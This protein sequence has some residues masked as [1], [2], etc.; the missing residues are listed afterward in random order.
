M[1][2]NRTTKIIVSAELQ[3]KK[4]EQDLLKLQSKLASMQTK[5]AKSTGSPVELINKALKDNDSKMLGYI[6]NQQ[7]RVS[8][9]RT[10]IESGAAKR[11]SEINR[12]YDEAGQAR[13]QTYRSKY[14]I[15]NASLAQKKAESK[16]ELD[17]LL[18]ARNAR[19]DMVRSSQLDYAQKNKYLERINK[20]YDAQKAKSVEAFNNFKSLNIDAPSVQKS[21]RSGNS[22][23]AVAR[24]AELGRLA[25]IESRA[26]SGVQR[27]STE[28]QKQFRQDFKQGSAARAGIDLANQDMLARER[29][30]TDTA[31]QA[32][33]AENMRKRTQSNRLNATRESARVQSV[34]NMSSL[35]SGLAGPVAAFASGSLIQKTGELQ[36]LRARVIQVS[37]SLREADQSMSSLRK[38]AEYTGQTMSGTVAMFAR[39]APAM[40]ANNLST[41]DTLN[42]VSAFQSSLRAS[43]TTMDQAAAAAYQLSQSLSSGVL[44]GDE[45]NSVIEG[46]PAFAKA[47]ADSLG[48]T[49]G[50][51]KRLGEQGQLTTGI[52]AAAAAEART[53]LDM[54]AKSVPITPMQQFSITVDRLVEAFDK[55]DNEY[56]ILDSIGKM[57]RLVA[58]N[59]TTAVSAIVGVTAAMASFK[60]IA[61][62]T[63]LTKGIGGLLGPM[64]KSSPV[65][66]AA[67]RSKQAIA[68]K[69]FVGPM[70]LITQASS[71]A[72]KQGKTMQRLNSGMDILNIG[73]FITV[74]AQT[75]KGAGATLIRVFAGLALAAGP[76]V[77]A[78]AGIGAISYASYKAFNRKSN[79]IEKSLKSSDA[80]LGK[81]S[82]ELIDSEN[83]GDI[84]RI[85]KARETAKNARNNKMAMLSM[86]SKYLS[87]SDERFIPNITEKLDLSEQQRLED[88][89][90]KQATQKGLRSG[91][92]LAMRGALKLDEVQGYG[93]MQVDTKV[94]AQVKQLGNLFSIFNKSAL[95]ASGVKAEATISDIAKAI[96]TLGETSKTSADITA[97]IVA[98]NRGLETLSGDSFQMVNTAILN[99]TD[100]LIE[101]MNAEIENKI[102]SSTSRIDSFEKAGIAVLSSNTRSSLFQANTKSSFA[103]ND[104]YTAGTDST[105]RLS[106]E[107]LDR[108]AIEKKEASA[109]LALKMSGL[110]KD[111]Q[112]KLQ[113][114]ALNTSIQ[115]EETDRSEQKT[116]D[117]VGKY[118][119]KNVKM[120]DASEKKKAELIAKRSKATTAVQR[121]QLD[122]QIRDIVSLSDDAAQAI[123]ETKSSV[124]D[125]KKLNVTA[126]IGNDPRANLAD[127]NE[128][129]AA[130]E[131]IAFAAVQMQENIERE[132]NVER[133]GI[134]LEYQNGLESSISEMLKLQEEYTRKVVDLDREAADKKLANARMVKDQQTSIAND[135]AKMKFLDR[136]ARGQSV[137]VFDDSYVPVKAAK[138]NLSDA[139]TR[140]Q[141]SSG[142]FDTRK[143]IADVQ[144]MAKDL[145]NVK[146][147]GIKEASNGNPEFEVLA[148]QVKARKEYLEVVQQA[149]QAEANLDAT[150]RSNALVA[151]GMNSVALNSALDEQ[152]SVSGMTKGMSLSEMKSAKAGMDKLQLT[153]SE[154]SLASL[155]TSIENALSKPFDIKINPNTGSQSTA[156]AGQTMQTVNVSFEGRNANIRVEPMD[157]NLLAQIAGGRK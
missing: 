108:M 97:S 141:G 78:M 94:A 96:E 120:V 122:S 106:S 138:E 86:E 103:N 142:E 93:G 32:I 80:N 64:A 38:T 61:I 55:L 101:T 17:G 35:G 53:V 128:I 117:T 83:S 19:R 130:R 74:I 123:Q 68:P 10:K 134:L 63:T 82:K 23:D 20:N 27:R 41:Q 131:S 46:A 70:P 72:G 50:G 92:V 58:D 26:L 5:L 98:L 33:I 150:Q 57:F 149:I 153:A 54:M 139:Q 1:A 129:T 13:L 44:R 62:A 39:I 137:G 113:A 40:Q 111:R 140:L 45:L 104:D 18:A 59:A 100:R 69:G 7:K 81:A 77:A 118:L 11:R 119:E 157:V 152:A 30:K 105:K 151:Q 29:I 126:L 60:A 22:I 91:D 147:S 2:N 73:T 107:T 49:V 155:R 87:A 48:V 66:I 34:A 24:K 8:D 121:N 12:R 79:F 42:V 4:L 133:L 88:K 6:E 124:Y 132:S 146:L 16:I 65:L 15:D 67:S 21:L 109:I 47:L 115:V 31:T 52:V 136:K 84:F 145:L 14:T 89:R 3:S 112:A 116:L 25:E 36:Q 43:G 90:A 110:D 85:A 114:L 99:L 95:L 76:F 144:A 71:T 56:G 148:A 9:L 135:E 75:V 37:S 156:N 28:N 102:K 51:M 143:A 125:S 127:L 154:T